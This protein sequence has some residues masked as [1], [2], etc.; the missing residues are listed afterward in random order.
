MPKFVIERDIPDARSL[1]ARD[2]KAIAAKS[3]G[4]LKKLGP[5]IQCV[6]SYV[7]GYRIHCVHIAPNE[8]MI[9]EYAEHV[10]DAATL[11][12][13]AI[14]S[15]EVLRHKARPLEESRVPSADPTFE[16]TALRAAG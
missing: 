8:A 2:L 7:T 9:L 5:S 6:H 11:C 16:P 15:P 3:C 10:V 14:D 13:G 4:A 1:S 12:S